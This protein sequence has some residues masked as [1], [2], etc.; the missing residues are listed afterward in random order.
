MQKSFK[1][2]KGIG[3][4]K[5]FPFVY[6]RKITPISFL[7]TS[8][9]PFFGV[10]RGLLAQDLGERFK[11]ID[12]TVKFSGI[13]DVMDI[14]FVRSLTKDIHKEEHLNYVSNPQELVDNAAHAA[15]LRVLDIHLDTWHERMKKFTET[16][17]QT[18]K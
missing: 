5:K 13:R 2:H 1:I 3:I 18:K 9:Y 16:Q 7:F 8:Y 10:Y 4:K 11:K 12:N 6:I 14:N 15:R 17:Q